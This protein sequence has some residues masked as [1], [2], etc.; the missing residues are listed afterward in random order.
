MDWRCRDGVVVFRVLA[1]PPVLALAVDFGA[2]PL[3]ISS[4]WNSLGI[5]EFLYLS[6]RYIL[7][8]LVDF[9]E[10]IFG[11]FFFIQI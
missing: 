11:M 8:S 7:K 3:I 1:H 10:N 5:E 4:S 9:F 6:S 2:V